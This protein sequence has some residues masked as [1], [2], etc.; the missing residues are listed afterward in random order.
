MKSPF[1]AIACLACLLAWSAPRLGLTQGF[2]FPYVI[3]VDPAGGRLVEFVL[4]DVKPAG[5]F[6]F[7]Q[8]FS[9]TGTA[10]YTIEMGSPVIK[11]PGQPETLTVQLHDITPIANSSP[12]QAGLLE[13]PPSAPPSFDANDGDLGCGTC[14][15]NYQVRAGTSNQNPK[16]PVALL[17]GATSAVLDTFDFDGFATGIA[18]CDDNATILVGLLS[19]DQSASQVRKLTISTTGELV[20]TGALVDLTVG[21]FPPAPAE[22]LCVSGSSFAFF[23]LGDEVISLSIAAMQIV[24]R[25]TLEGDRANGLAMSCEL[26]RIYARSGDGID[27]DSIECFSFDPGT[28]DI[29]TPRLFSA[30]AAPLLPSFLRSPLA[31]SHD[32]SRILAIE[33]TPPGLRVFNGQNGSNLGLAAD[34]GLVQPSSVSLIPCCFTEPVDPRIAVYQRKIQALTTQIGLTKRKLVRSRKA[35]NARKTKQYSA[36]LR[37]LQRQLR[38]FRAKLAALN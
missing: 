4:P 20:D 21:Q 38:Q 17:D 32:G 2:S 14:D 13:P 31:V 23:R 37:T 22:I 18:C 9:P 24:D 28:G 7:P 15:G 25:V 12:P 36:G 8:G 10:Y 34:P 26:S 5:E 1:S 19:T 16:T 11:V 33:E 29:A 6:E 27:P 30:N 35:R 3:V